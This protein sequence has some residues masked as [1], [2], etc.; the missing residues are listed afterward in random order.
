M[1]QFNEEF[2]LENNPEALAS[3]KTAFEHFVTEGWESGAQANAEGEVLTGDDIVI[4]AVALPGE[5]LLSL[6][7]EMGADDMRA[8]D[9]GSAAL[10]V[11]AL[12]ITSFD[13]FKNMDASET[14]Q[15]VEDTPE[16]LAIMEVDD[17][18]FLESGGTF[19]VGQTMDGLDESTTA[20][21]LKGL[22]GEALGFVDAKETYDMGAKLTAMGD[23]NLATVMGG[24]EV[25]GMTFMDGMD[26]MD[27]ETSYSQYS[28]GAD[29]F[30][31]LA[32]S[33]PLVSYEATTGVKLNKVVKFM[34]L[35]KE[36]KVAIMLGLGVQKYYEGDQIIRAIDCFAA[37]IGIHNKSAGG[38]WYLADAG[39]GYEKQFETKA[40]NY[41]DITNVDFSSYEL[42]FIQGAN[43]VV[44][45]PNSKNV[46]EGLKNTYVVYFG[47]TY[48][49][50]CEYANLIIP[51]CDF[52]RKHDVRLSYG[53]ENKAI[54]YA[55]R[56]KNENTRQ[57][58]WHYRQYT[59]RK[60]QQAG[61]SH[62][63]PVCKN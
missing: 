63:Q 28:T 25:D 27:D 54:S 1:A 16:S 48:N 59:G 32:K 11:P 20:D 29:W 7:S 42:V 58:S 41:V 53:H 61:A 24:L 60:N 62:G 39:H 3:E 21:V 2:Y 44:S 40:K 51:S 49:D 33:R 17:F 19:D 6:V 36:K 26:D 47:T 30:V 15:L 50:T 8:V 14:A 43:P 46:I 23:E 12:M 35:I 22:G 13:V 4:E 45:I 52:L 37:Y 34:E 31:D 38:V 9:A 5:A 57:Y 18:Q 10:D 56:E 55:V